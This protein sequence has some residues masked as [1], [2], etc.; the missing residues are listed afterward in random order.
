M[1]VIFSLV[2][3]CPFYYVGAKLS[4]CQIVRCQIVRFYYVGAKL[5]W[6][7]IVR[8]Q[9]VLV[10]NCPG[11]KLSGAKL[12]GAK[13]SYHPKTKTKTREGE[14]LRQG[15]RADQVIVR[16][17]SICQQCTILR[18]QI[19]NVDLQW[20]SS[21]RLGKVAIDMTNE[22]WGGKQEYL[23]RKKRQCVV[24]CDVSFLLRF[25]MKPVFQP[26]AKVKAVSRLDRQWLERIL[27]KANI[28]RILSKVQRSHI[29]R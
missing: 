5:S 9:I 16:A 21:K 12:S 24:S 22:V 27:S 13:L 2:P 1:D 28:E 11:A 26:R 10:P 17:I 19:S 29:K 20:T 4:W 23:E 18:H 3:N 25:Y 14:R 8:C 15:S 7:Q 6:C